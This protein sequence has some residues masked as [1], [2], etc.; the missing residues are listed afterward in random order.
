MDN[1]RALRRSSWQRRSCWER[2][3][4]GGAPTGGSGQPVGHVASHS[5][6]RARLCRRR[7]LGQPDAGR[8]GDW[9]EPA[10]QK[11]LADAGAT[12]L[13]TDAKGSAGQQATDV[14]SLIAQ[15]ANVVIVD[16]TDATAILPTVTSAIEHGIAVIAYDRLIEDPR[17]L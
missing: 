3:G 14:E 5:G 6:D 2:A 12:Y 7:L 16:P 17:A 9:D 1:R 11:A 13:S 8:W 15:G 10:I 4:A